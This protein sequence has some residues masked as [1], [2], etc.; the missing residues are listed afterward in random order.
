MDPDL[1][2]CLR[3]VI[4]KIKKLARGEHLAIGLNSKIQDKATTAVLE[5]ARRLSYSQRIVVVTTND[6]IRQCVKYE[7]ILSQ[8]L[9]FQTIY[10]RQ[11]I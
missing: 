11:M 8:L 1:D 5:A 10:Q 2:R 3:L 7:H 4:E 9:S 6:N